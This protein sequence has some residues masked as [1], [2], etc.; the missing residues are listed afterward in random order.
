MK[1]HSCGTGNLRGVILNRAQAQ[2]YF[3]AFYRP[4]TNNMSKRTDRPNGVALF[5]WCTHQVVK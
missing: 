1:L 3:S 5:H 4:E 2:L